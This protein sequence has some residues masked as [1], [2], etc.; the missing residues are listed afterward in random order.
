MAAA[1]TI[2]EQ[3]LSKG[4]LEA[5]LEGGLLLTQHYDD[6]E[7]GDVLAQLSARFHTL[8]TDVQAGTI[9][10]EDYRIERARINR[11]MIDWVDEIPAEWTDASLKAAGFSPGKYD[12]GSTA[13]SGRRSIWIVAAL[14]AVLVAVWVLRT[15]F[16][17]AEILE[18]NRAADPAIAR[19]TISNQRGSQSPVAGIPESSGTR[20]ATD[21]KF[22]SFAKMVIAEDMERGYVGDK[23]A[24]RNVRNKQIICCFSDAKDFSGGKA[25]VSEDGVSYFYIDK[26]GNKLK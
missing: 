17:P 24:F 16:F 23:L 19:D 10:D 25:Y 7:K 14:L 4:K 3:L 6:D 21:E 8:I 11:A 2:L 1:R 26:N 12:V 9:S 15:H 22:R 5:A 20:R 13:A 18:K